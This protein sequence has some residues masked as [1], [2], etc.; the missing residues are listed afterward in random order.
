MLRGLLFLLRSSACGYRP[1]PKRLKKQ[2]QK[3]QAPFVRKI[4][5][6]K[7]RKKVFKDSNKFR[8]RPGRCSFV[9]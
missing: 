3:S 2:N 5:K 6:K 4:K 9:W 8:N 7:R 1:A